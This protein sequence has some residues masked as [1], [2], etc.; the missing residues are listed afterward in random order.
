M[1]LVLAVHATR[2]S[3]GTESERLECWRRCQRA[4]SLAGQV[5]VAVAVLEKAVVVQILVVLQM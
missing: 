5:A 2:P 3:G 4:H 1:V